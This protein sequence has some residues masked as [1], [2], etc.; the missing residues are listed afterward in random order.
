MSG[1]VYCLTNPA[2]PGYIKIG[3]TTDLTARLRS[4]DTTSVPLPFECVFAVEIP[5]PEQVERLL[6][7]TFADARVRDSREFFEVGELRV[8]AAMR[9]T[10]GRDVTPEEDV[11][12]DAE[13]QRALDSARA[14]RQ[15]FNF[16][17]V[18]LP[19][20]AL[21]H[22]ASDPSVTCSVAGRRTV[23]FEGQEV[24]ISAAAT[25]VLRRQSNYGAWIHRATLSVQG[26]LYWIY[27]GESLDDRRRRMEAGEDV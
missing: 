23:L 9:L 3:R 21:L 5:N 17:M 14:R 25:T 13:A 24:S 16:E 1:I 22:F 12:E 15:V 8:V 6:H 26:P 20:G 19:H 4:L 10:G 11:V 27:D 2:M 7:E 18:G